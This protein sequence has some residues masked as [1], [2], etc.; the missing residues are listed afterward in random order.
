MKPEMQVG[1][2]LFGDGFSP[3]EVTRTVGL[4]PTKTW[5]KGESVQN[6]LIRRKVDGWAFEL[7]YEK[8]LELEEMIRRLLDKLEPYREKLV[9]VSRDLGLN[10]QF[11][12]VMY[13][14]NQAPKGHIAADVMQRVASY[15]ADLDMDIIVVPGDENG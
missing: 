1:L 5:R 4:Q 9:E 12:W 15:G 14:A 10:M 7:P 11:E 2:R 8:T 3:E 13:I 6:T